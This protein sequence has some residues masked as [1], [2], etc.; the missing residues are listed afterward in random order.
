MALVCRS[1]DF[2][3]LRPDSERK[4]EI[5]T[6]GLTYNLLT[7]YTSFIAVDEIVANPS[8][9]SRKIKQPLPLP[10]G[11]SD[12][13]VG[14]IVPTTPEPGIVTLLG[15]LAIM[16]LWSVFVKNRRIDITPS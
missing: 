5:T 6:L 4:A 15:V 3:K 2:E 14:G 10:K 9:K 16:G 12:L 13:A 8:A 7:A 11:V 1:G